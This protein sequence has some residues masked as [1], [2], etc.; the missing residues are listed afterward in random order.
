MQKLMNAY[1]NGQLTNADVIEELKKMAQDISAAGNEGITLGL[2]Q[3]ELAFYHALS[4]P[5]RQ[6][7]YYTN[8]QL[9]AMTQELTET[10]RKNRTIDWNKKDGPRAAMKMLVK[11]LLKKYKYPPEGEEEAINTV[12]SQCEMWAGLS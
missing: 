4:N 10:L 11:R 7:D 9:K 2:T 8:D 12:I 6:K 3:D 1:R 5:L